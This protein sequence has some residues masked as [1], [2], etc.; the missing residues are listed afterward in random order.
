MMVME[1]RNPWKKRVR[2]EGRRGIYKKGKPL[3][4][5]GKEEVVRM[6]FIIWGMF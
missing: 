2:V 6:A 3:M 5:N 4:E 1:A